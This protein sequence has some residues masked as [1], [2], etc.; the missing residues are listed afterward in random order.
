MKLK[1]SSALACFVFASAA[2]AQSSV[3][4]YGSIDMGLAYQS[5]SAKGFPP[6]LPLAALHNMGSTFGL[7]NGGLYGSFLGF[8]GTEDI[9]GGYYVNFKLQGNFNATTGSLQLADSAGASAL[10]AQQ[11]SVGVSGPFGSLDFGRQ[12]IP[13]AYAMAETDAR[14]SQYFGSILTAWLSL[15]TAAGWQGASTNAPIGALYDSNAI[16]YH[17]PKFYGASLAL[18]FAPGGV[19]GQPQGNTR[20]SAVL[21]YSNYGL[22]LAAVYYNGHDTNP[23]SI[24]L[25]AGT[26]ST[27]PITGQDNNRFYYLG[28]MYTYRSLSVSTS[29]AI[30]KN[31]AHPNLAN[32]ELFSGAL[33]YQFSPF[34]RVSMGDYYVKDRNNSSNHSNEIAIGANYSLSKRTTLYADVGY[35]N[36]KGNMVQMIAYGLPVAPGQST[37]AAILGIRHSF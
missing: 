21:Q 25:P 28:A 29:Y 14:G 7:T 35:V 30:A 31:P 20:E 10:F 33:A 16:V 27:A 36:N 8:K 5:T 2:N 4:L 15:N 17:S 18:E 6:S 37:T 34:F 9:G 1:V 24:N 13:M 23:Y 22:Q 3:A 12:I 26:L 11:A 32:L 19:A